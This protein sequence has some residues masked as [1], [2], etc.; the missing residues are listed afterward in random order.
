M[1]LKEIAGKLGCALEGDGE[2]EI[3]GIAGIERAQP[4]ELTFLTDRRYRPALKTTRASAIIIG[5]EEG[6]SPMPALRS[7]NPHLDFAR[8]LEIFHQPP[9]YEPGIH[10]TA[11]V[12]SSA[13]IGSGAH[14][15]PHCFVDE[16]VVLGKNAVLHSMVVLYRDA[17]IG[18]DFFAHSH[19]VVRGGCRIGNRVLLQNGVIIGSDGFGFARTNEGQWRKIQQTGIVVVEDDVE[20]QA[21]SIVDRATIGE[22][23]IHRGAKLDNLVHVAHSCEVGEDTLLCSQVG[24]AGSTHVGKRCILAGQVGAAGHLSIGD[25]AMLTAQ[26]GVPHDVP[27]GAHYSGAPAMEHKKWL[28][29]SAVIEAL[30]EI[31]KEVRRLREEVEK[32]SASQR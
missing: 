19:V 7:Q 3:T 22:T 20:I 31:Q 15:G 18:D 25:G 12:A 24:L 9:R 17:H 8:A 29:S 21:G 1:K 28:K 6:L 11:V 32:L 16:G 14:I 26:S 27:A 10:P 30:P 4:G 13:K 2:I 5:P 23:Q